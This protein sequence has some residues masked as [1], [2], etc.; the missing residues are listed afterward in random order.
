MPVRKKVDEDTF[1]ATVQEGGRI[2]LNRGIREFL[3]VSPGDVVKL[4]REENPKQV[5]LVKMDLV[6][7]E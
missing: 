6:E 5:S 2:T 1:L 4:K 3:D 7:A